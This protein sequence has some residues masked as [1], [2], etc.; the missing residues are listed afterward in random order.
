M[1][2]REEVMWKQRSRALWLKC[3]DR[4]T[5]FFHVTS[6]QRQRTNKIEGLKDEGVWVDSQEDIE[7]VILDYFTN[8]YSSD[9]PV[10]FEASFGAVR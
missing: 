9:H 6:S 3:G 7:R 1:L 2:T 4:N 10:S 8:I 5:K